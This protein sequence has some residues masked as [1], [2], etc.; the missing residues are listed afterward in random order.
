MAPNRIIDEFQ[1]HSFEIHLF[2]ICMIFIWCKRST[3]DIILFLLQDEAIRYFIIFILKGR[4]ILD[5][6]LGDKMNTEHE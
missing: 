5:Y 4:P 6:P 2:H 3:D 1:S